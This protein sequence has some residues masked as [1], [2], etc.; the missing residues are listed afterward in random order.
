[1][2]RN[3]IKIITACII[4]ITIIAQGT[5]LNP[6]LKLLNISTGVDV[7]EFNHDVIVL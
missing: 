4:L 7:E 2:I 1:M 3:N 6:I 5:F